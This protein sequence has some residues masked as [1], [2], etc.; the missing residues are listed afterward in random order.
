MTIKQAY[1]E[2]EFVDIS[3]LSLICRSK[4]FSPYMKSRVQMLCDVLKLDIICRAKSCKHDMI[5]LMAK[6]AVGNINYS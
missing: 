2:I 4:S 6:L 5:R 1:F 3:L